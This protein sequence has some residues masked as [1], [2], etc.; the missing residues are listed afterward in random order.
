MA[1]EWCKCGDR[2]HA[3]RCYFPGCSCTDP[4]PLRTHDKAEDENAR[5]IETHA[6]KSDPED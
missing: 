3:G 6:R 1:T 4:R 2:I 5:G